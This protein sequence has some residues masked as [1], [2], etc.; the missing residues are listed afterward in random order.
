MDKRENC[1]H[2]ALPPA[3]DLTGAGA[4]DE[5]ND[6]RKVSAD[7]ALGEQMIANTLVPARPDLAF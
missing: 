6:C 5:N 2:T 3:P 1:N 4:S 7:N